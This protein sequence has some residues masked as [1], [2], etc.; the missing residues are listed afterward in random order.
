MDRARDFVG[1]ADC[2]PDITWPNGARVAVNFVLNYEEGSEYA[3]A[4]DGRTD[5]TLVEVAQARVPVGDRDLGAES[6]F[7][8]GSRVGFWRLYRLFRE[9][10]LPLT[11]F[12]SA[13][14]LE[15]N[16]EAVRAIRATDWDVVCH[17]WR[18]IEHYL[19]DEAT[20]REHIARG[21]D[22]LTRLLGRSPQGFYCRYAP[23]VATRRLVV[24]HGGF[25]YDSDA[26]NDELPYWTEVGGKAH[27]VVPYSLAT[28]DAKMLGAGGLTGR[29][30]G[31]FLIDSVETLIAEAQA[32]PRMMS[33]GMHCRIL[34]HPG[35]V[36]A[37]RAFMAHL[38]GRD[39][40]WV[41]RRADIAAHWRKVAPYT[42]KRHAL[43]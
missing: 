28:N 16:P 31:E 14:A 17:G 33:V 35:R 37:L 11:V 36:P 18:W 3:I 42:E 10:G 13:L 5:T 15:R 39:D 23:S 22:T 29:L 2:P 34:G 4:E 1:Y 21:H 32:H 9:T 7:E 19:L 38:A 41:C 27:L 20:E 40:V 26:Y 8:Y 12:A 25:A 30:F 24:E 43:A 6:M